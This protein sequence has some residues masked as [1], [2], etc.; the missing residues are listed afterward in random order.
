MPKRKHQKFNRPRK[1]FDI[2]LMKEEQAL[3]KKYGLKNRK[4]V[5]RANYAIE[6][7]R[8]IAK[9]LIT[10]DKEEQDKFIQRQKEKGFAV[11]TIA[12]VLGLKNEDYLKRRLESIVVKKGLA[13]THNQA[14]QAI[15]HKH[16]TIDGHIIDAPSHLTTLKEEASLAA[17]RLIIPKAEVISKEEKQLLKQMKAEEEKTEE[18]E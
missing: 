17:N 7:I 9:D 16:I 18:I 13:K 6:I 2:V 4:E 5:W 11:E 3:I 1:I 12:D 15:T 10:A 8:N 14:R